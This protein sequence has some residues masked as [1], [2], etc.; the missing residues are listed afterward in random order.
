MSEKIRVVCSECDRKLACPVSAAGKKVRCTSCG[1]AIRVPSADGANAPP[2]AP[3]KK[4]RPASSGKPQQRQRRAQPDFDDDPY[5]STVPGSPTGLPPRARKGKNSARKK[6][7]Q[8]DQGD[9]PWTKKIHVGFGIMGAAV[10]SNVAQLA[11]MGPPNTSTAEGK[12][13]AFGQGLVTVG[14]LIFGLVIVIRGFMANRSG[15]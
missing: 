9:R 4:R 10:V 15:K 1:A 6:S 12:G 7:V 2:S 11:I 5:Q 14:G 13:Q 8:S 3:P